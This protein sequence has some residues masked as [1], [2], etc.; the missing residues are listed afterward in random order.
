MKKIILFSIAALMFLSAC[1]TSNR[2]GNTESDGNLDDFG[3]TD[4]FRAE[5]TSMNSVDWAGVYKGMLPCA[6]CEGIVIELQLNDDL[7]YEKVMTYIG[8]GDNKFHDSGTF[9]WAKDGGR[10]K[11]TDESADTEEWYRVGENQLFAL[12]TEGNRIEGA[13]PEEM[14]ILKKIDMDF[15]ITEKYWKLIELNGKEMSVDREIADREPHFILHEV[16]NRVS[17]NTGCNN[18]LGSFEL[19]DVNGVE[20]KIS[21]SQMASTRMA[22][23]DVDY[24]QEYLNVFEEGKGF[25]IKNDTLFLINEEGLPIAKFAAVYE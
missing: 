22:C 5:H 18:I 12:D 2:T 17:G 6:D 1:N 7:T 16:D 21:F 3:I 25:S 8:K 15:V 14:Y 10:I 19:S 20:G 13:I 24:E 11:I 23:I 4:E 9:E